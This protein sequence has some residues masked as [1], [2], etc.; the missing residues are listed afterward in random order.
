MKNMNRTPISCTSPPKCL[1]V[2]PCANSCRVVTIVTVSQTT[3]TV[4]HRST[5]PSPPA[6]SARLAQR[7]PVAAMMHRSDA[8][9]A[10]AVQQ[11][12]SLG[13]SQVRSRS[14]SRTA[15]RQ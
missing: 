7:M 3:T 2:S 13:A 12:A 11:N 10:G 1:H 15:F 8:R 6:T 14:G 4:S 5:L 9:K